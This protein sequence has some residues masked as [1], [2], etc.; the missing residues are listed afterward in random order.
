MSLARARATGEKE[1]RQNKTSTAVYG[2]V[3]NDSIILLWLAP[4]AGCPPTR[5][6]FYFSEAACTTQIFIT[7]GTGKAI[8]ARAI[9]HV[10]SGVLFINTNRLN[11]T[12]N[13]KC[14]LDSAMRIEKNLTKKI[15]EK[16]RQIKNK[17]IHYFLWRLTP[18]ESHSGLCWPLRRHFKSR[19]KFMS[20]ESREIY[21]EPHV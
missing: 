16:V 17:I 15:F 9:F 8:I 14:Q 18:I 2:N 1:T 6:N 21:V 10:E 13:C 12:C 5:W 3:A 7:R 19:Q 11:F 4:G 20:H